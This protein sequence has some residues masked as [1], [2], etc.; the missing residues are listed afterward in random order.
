MKAYQQNNAGLWLDH[1]K[2]IIVSITDKGQS[3]KRIESDIE[4]K[5]RQ[6]FS[7]A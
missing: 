7:E 2:A 1:R 3:I 5:V 6:F 4:R